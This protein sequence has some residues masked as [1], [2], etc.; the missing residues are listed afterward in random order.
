VEGV[1]M[2]QFYLP[3]QESDW[4]K[5]QPKDYLLELVREQMQERHD[6]AEAIQSDF[7]AAKPKL[8]SGSALFHPAGERSHP[9]KP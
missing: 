5:S 4:L 8:L 9:Q 7:V 3:K 1:E 2:S 6:V